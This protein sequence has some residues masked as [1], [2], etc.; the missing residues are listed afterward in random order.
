MALRSFL[1]KN[2]QFIRIQSSEYS[3]YP[4]FMIPGVKSQTIFKLDPQKS[5]KDLKD[6]ISSSFST[7][8]VH[9]FGIDGS[10]LALSSSLIDCTIDPLYIK[11]GEDKM[12]TLYNLNTNQLHL[13]PHQRILVQQYEKEKNLSREEAEVLGTFNH[14]IIKELQ[15]TTSN[16]VSAESFNLIVKN[17]VLQYGTQV[18]Q[19]KRLFE[20]QLEL[21]KSQY[22]YELDSHDQIAKTASVYANKMVKRFFYVIFLQFAAV[23]YGTYHLYSW[24]IMEP[25]TC[26]MTMGDVCVGYLF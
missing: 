3:P 2:S 1:L 22:A 17:A 26:M 15:E 23:Q 6:D 24:D 5:L 13:T 11:I 4:Y 14:Y 8:N 9:F 12:F 10:K 18:L 20:T 19:Q 21:I 16:E 7:N 25:I